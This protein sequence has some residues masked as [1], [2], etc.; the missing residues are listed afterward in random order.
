MSNNAHSDYFFVAAAAGY[1]IKHSVFWRCVAK[2]QKKY[3]YL[4]DFSHIPFW[5]LENNV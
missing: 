2:T 4:Y 1:A 3:L 5:Q